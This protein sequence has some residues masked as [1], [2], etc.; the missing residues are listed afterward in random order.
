MNPASSG[1][2]W[3]WAVAVGTPLVAAAGAMGMYFYLN[4]QQSA[5]PAAGS[6]TP[7][8]GAVLPGD[9]EVAISLTP[10]ASARAG[11][12]TAP[13]RVGHVSSALKLPGIVEP[14][15]YRQVVV[16]SLAAGQVRSVI[17]ELGAH[18]R[19]GEPLA[20]IHSSELAESERVY[21]SMRAELEA[22]HHRLARLE[23]LVKIGAAS[24]QELEV[25]RAEH[26]KHSTDVEGAR[27]RLILFGLTPNQVDGLIDAARIDPTMSI[28]SPIEG[29]IT[30]RS[31]N[32]GQNVDATTELFTIVNL[33]SVWVVGNLYER[34]LG[35]VRLGTTASM[36]TTALPGQTWRGT[37]S[38]IDPQVVP[39]TRTA[40]L[41]IE[42]PNPGERLRFGMYL[43]VVLSDTA[44][45]NVLL[46]P[47][48][49]VQTIGTQSVV[50]VEDARQGGRYAERSITL[51]ASS[52]ED[53][54]VT[55]GLRE[56][57][58][59]VVTGSFSL[60]AERDRLGLPPPVMA[61]PPSVDTTSAVVSRIQIAVTKEGF[62]PATVAASAGVPIEL[63]FTRKTDDTCATEVAV[64]SLNLRK[65]LPLNTP[66]AVPL[67]PKQ[68]GEIAFACGMN[69]LRGTVVVR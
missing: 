4:A 51:G 53:V 20:T 7:A 26:T 50:Y 5:L 62:V 31:I 15:A 28:T 35:R 24:Q 57:E 21:V 45:A 3:F 52:G 29:V 65:P 16:T 39:E 37:V 42:V 67:T 49:A 25:A 61:A 6:S 58:P 68:A 56:G 33:S 36:T 64:P 22:A 32:R 55:S 30:Q 34:D 14:N 40:R 17:G 59:V 8:A 9:R 48:T 13:V 11:I 27:A 60:R 43:D 66:V 23:G 38:Y 10:E 54:E 46:V 69:M 44:P 19:Q 41:R 47:R 2:R 12:R 18:V 63:V 1:R